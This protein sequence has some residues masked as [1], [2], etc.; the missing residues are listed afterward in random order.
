MLLSTELGHLSSPSSWYKDF[1]G[2]QWLGHIYLSGRTPKSEELGSYIS[3][4]ECKRHHHERAAPVQGNNH[5]YLCERWSLWTSHT[6]LHNSRDLFCMSW[7]ISFSSLWVTDHEQHLLPSTVWASSAYWKQCS[8]ERDSLTSEN[9]PAMIQEAQ[10]IPNTEGPSRLTAR[11]SA[12][13]E[14][15]VCEV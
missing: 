8:W 7:R 2:V 5:P 4:L 15:N 14:V 6:A 9:E 3:L 11:A 10:T 1:K 13:V 12:G